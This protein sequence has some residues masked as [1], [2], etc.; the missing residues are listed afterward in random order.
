MERRTTWNLEPLWL[1]CAKANVF[2]SNNIVTGNIRVSGLQ[3]RNRPL[4]ALRNT[5]VAVT[6]GIP[7]IGITASISKDK[8]SSLWK[9]LPQ[10]LPLLSSSTT[11]PGNEFR[12]QLAVPALFHMYRSY[13][14][15][16]QAHEI[17]LGD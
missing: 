10:P 13:L 2:F 8:Q 4:Y 3:F 6:N 9:S 15:D 11:A 12:R 17:A 16:T 5:N 7:R 1:R 14:S